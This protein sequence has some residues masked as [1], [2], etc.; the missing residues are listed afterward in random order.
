[1]K[2]CDIIAKKVALLSGDGV[3]PE[4]MAS[5]VNV[6]QSVTDDVEV[7]YAE[8]GLECY[9]KTGE[10]L[11]RST[12]DIIDE[13][14]AVLFGTVDE[15]AKDPGYK[16]PYNIVCKRFDLSSQVKYFYK[17]SS[18]MGLG[19]VD[20]FLVTERPD[21]NSVV[22]KADLDGVTA[23]RRISAHKCKRLCRTARLVAEINKRDEITLAHDG[24]HLEL[25]KNILTAEFREAMKGS[26]VQSSEMSYMD[27]IKML[28]T[29]PYRVGFIVATELRGEYV[30]SIMTSLSGRANTMPIGCVGGK[31]GVFRPDHGPMYE[32]AGKDSV[33]PTGAILTACAMLDFTG[34]K[35]DGDL[36][37]DAVKK[38]YREG[39]RTKDAG[40]DMGT[41][42]F[43]D[44]IVS[45]CN[46]SN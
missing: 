40:G 3:G 4:I 13:S 29:N 46:E 17:L 2:G 14:V 24:D 32:L 27:V 5:A 18:D 43:T 34:N 36:I 44:L 19:E 37:R 6:L 41:F 7:L 45:L 11:P 1:M 22:E 39:Y 8:A 25:S 20:A 10:Y 12:I 33:N 15:Y 16:S 38:A 9:R 30:D 23:E 21:G 26:T 31:K 28:M 42:A 35:S